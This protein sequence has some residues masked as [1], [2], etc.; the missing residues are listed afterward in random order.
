MSYAYVS[1][2]T[3]TLTLTVTHTVTVLHGSRLPKPTP[4]S[5]AGPMQ[6]P[7][8]AAAVQGAA[9]HKAHAYYIVHVVA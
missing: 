3:L 1:H 5:V 7:F 6:L 8:L 4:V 9:A 2:F